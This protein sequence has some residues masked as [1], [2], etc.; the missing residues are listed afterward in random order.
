MLSFSSLPLCSFFRLSHHDKHSRRTFVR[1][2]SWPKDLPRASDIT[3]SEHGSYRSFRSRSLWF[4]CKF[5]SSPSD[6]SH[7]LLTNRVQYRPVGLFV[8][9]FSFSFA[10]LLIAL[11]S[12][13]RHIASP[14]KI[15]PIRFFTLPD[16][17]NR[18]RRAILAG[19]KLWTWG[20]LLFS[21]REFRFLPSRSR[22]HSHDSPRNSDNSATLL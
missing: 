13:G 15:A 6:Q 20:A 8:I 16:D 4:R 17:Q 9:P 22:S 7:N 18:Q 11:F 12:L 19:K 1:R 5:C 3:G 21:A 2:S 14:S 10:L